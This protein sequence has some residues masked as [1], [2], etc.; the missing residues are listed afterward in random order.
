M[1][2]KTIHTATHN[3]RTITMTINTMTITMTINTMTTIITIITITDQNI[4]VRSD[5][6]AWLLDSMEIRAIPG[7]TQ[8]D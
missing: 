7:G 8:P 5:M 3:T 1:N 4:P 6:M 2:D